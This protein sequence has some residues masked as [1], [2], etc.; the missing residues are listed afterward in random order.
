MVTTDLNIKSARECPKCGSDSM[1]YGT[2]M[3]KTGEIRR[4][5]RCTS[6]G[7][8]FSTIE[9]FQKVIN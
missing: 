5:R 9:K 7:L 4:R 3:L 8:R 1:V 2:K 6:C